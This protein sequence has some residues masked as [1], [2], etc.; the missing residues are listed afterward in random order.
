ML[1]YAYTPDQACALGQGEIGE[2]FVDMRA[3]RDAEHD[4]RASTF[5]EPRCEDDPD[6]MRQAGWHM[7][8]EYMCE[9][10]GL[11]PFGMEAF[12]VCKSSGLCKECGC[13]NNDEI[14]QPCQHEEGW[15]VE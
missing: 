14:D 3:R 15:S 5:T 7:E 12:A 13:E 2:S 4:V 1:V 10:C 6:Y 8:G 9:S 11:A